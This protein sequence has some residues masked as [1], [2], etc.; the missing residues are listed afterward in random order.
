MYTYTCMRPNLMLRYKLSVYN[1]EMWFTHCP[2]KGLDENESVRHWQCMLLLL[3]LQNMSE[4][5]RGRNNKD[6][7]AEHFDQG[8]FLAGDLRQLIVFALHIC[9]SVCDNVVPS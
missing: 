1:R 5:S 6:I 9:K 3:P 8:V 2:C 7:I 4:L